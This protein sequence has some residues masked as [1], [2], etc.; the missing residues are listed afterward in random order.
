MKRPLVAAILNFNMAAV[1]NS[2]LPMSRNLVKPFSMF[3]CVGAILNSNMAATEN[4]ALL[5]R[6]LASGVLRAA[7]TYL[8]KYI[9]SEGLGSPE[10]EIVTGKRIK[11]ILVL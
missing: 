5:C 11:R 9:F 3:Y 4:E 2:V 7:P 10:Y 8:R 6:S 1:G